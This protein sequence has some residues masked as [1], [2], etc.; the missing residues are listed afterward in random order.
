MLRPNW[1]S[2]SVQETLWTT[3]K[4]GTSDTANEHIKKLPQAGRENSTNKTIKLNTCMAAA[5]Y[6]PKNYLWQEQFFVRT[7]LKDQLVHLMITN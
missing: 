5:Q 2:S 4:Q 6:Q 3:T 7:K 1:P